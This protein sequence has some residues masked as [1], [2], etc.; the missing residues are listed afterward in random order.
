MT[1]TNET[2]LEAQ[3]AT[4]QAQIQLLMNGQIKTKSPARRLQD[5]RRICREKHFGSWKDMQDGKIQYGPE[6]KR[7]SDY[8][9]I[10]D[11][12]TRE[13]GLLFKYSRGKSNGDVA[14]T[15]IIM[16]ENDLK[17]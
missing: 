8:D 11:I 3:I 13:T 5:V 9:A 2:T 14:I 4:L 16:D 6:S 15:S 10:M 1:Q 7:Y 12:V 17:D